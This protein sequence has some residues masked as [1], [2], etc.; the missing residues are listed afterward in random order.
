VKVFPLH[1]FSGLF[2]GG[3]KPVPENYFLNWQRSPGGIVYKSRLPEK[4]GVWNIGGDSGRLALELTGQKS[5]CFFAEAVIPKIVSL[6]FNYSEINFETLSGKWLVDSGSETSPVVATDVASL[7]QL[8]GLQRLLF[9]H[10][11][12]SDDG[13]LLALLGGEVPEKKWAGQI[14]FLELDHCI[15]TGAS[16]FSLGKYYDLLSADILKK[17]GLET[18][19]IRKC[20]F[21]SFLLGQYQYFLGARIEFRGGVVCFRRISEIETFQKI[22]DRH[23]FLP[24]EFLRKRKI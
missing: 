16:D 14:N 5:P 12:I 8:P 24:G 11:V 22:G 19:I 13:G 15:I 18:L 21:Y 9:H 23:Q 20:E 7:E 17:P 4:L 1:F 3:I 10:S 2:R 6:S